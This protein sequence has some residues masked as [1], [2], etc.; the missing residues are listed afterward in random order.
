MCIS[1]NEIQRI[2]KVS[3]INLGSTSDRPRIAPDRENTMKYDEFVRNVII[4]V[5][6]KGCSEFPFGGE[7]K[8]NYTLIVIIFL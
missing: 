7:L 4:M 1:H 2:Y 8:E 6:M 5:Y 3:G